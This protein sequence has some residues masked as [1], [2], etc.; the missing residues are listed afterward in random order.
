MKVKFDLTKPPGQRVSEVY[1][2]CATCPIPRY[3]PLI[4]HKYYRIIMSEWMYNGGSGFDQI[5]KRARF[6][7]PGEILHKCHILYFQ[8]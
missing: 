3:E 4:I 7:A 5:K 6:W 8:N 1:V 2:R